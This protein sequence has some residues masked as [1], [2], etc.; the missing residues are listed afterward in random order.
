[1][2][3][4]GPASGSGRVIRG[5]AW[6]SDARYLRYSERNLSDPSK[7][8]YRCRIPLRAGNAALIAILRLR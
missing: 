6:N 2:R 1:M 3:P 7:A 4:K 5:G 8:N